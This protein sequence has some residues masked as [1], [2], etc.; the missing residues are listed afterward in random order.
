MQNELTKVALIPAFEPGE[1]FIELISGLRDAGF[2]CVAVDDGSGGDYAEIFGRASRLAVVLTHGHNRGK[3]AALKTGLG[4]IA[5]AY[6]RCVVATVDAD[7]QHKVCDALRVAEDAGD[8]TGA[9][10]LGSRAFTGRVP[11]RSR[12]GND[13]TR[14]VF[15]A[16]TGVEV[17][18]TQTGLRAFDGSLI[19][20]MLSVKGERYEYEMNVLLECAKMGVPI[21]ETRIDTVYLNGNSGSH[22][23]VLRDSFLIYGEIFKFAA[24]SLTGFAV[25]YGLYSLLVLATAGLGSV[26]VPLS[27]VTARIVSATVNFSMNKKLVFKSDASSLRTGAQYFL[28]AGLILLGNTVLLSYLVNG[29]GVNR[30]AGKIVTEITFFTLS[31]IA[32]KFI[33]FKKPAH[34]RAIQ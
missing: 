10:C 27:N 29:L 6:P 15:K 22:F 3:G 33:I 16:S 17:F 2:Q 20:Y 4:Y 23:H 13:I 28:L 14:K 24:S 12:M 7:G 18:D 32:Q 11:A 31:F 19:P 30:Y 26:S 21:R 5:S 8:H 25:D 9:L 34:R 1:A